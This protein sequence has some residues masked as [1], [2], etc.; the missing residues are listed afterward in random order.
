MS[1]A[2]LRFAVIGTVKNDG[3]IAASDLTAGVAQALRIDEEQVTAVAWDLV[4][5]GVLTYD[6]RGIFYFLTLDGCTYT[7]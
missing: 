5:D 7:R 4:E 2:L 1:D 3:P 6:I